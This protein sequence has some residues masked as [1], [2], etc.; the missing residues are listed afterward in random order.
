[1]A[2][3]SMPKN[4]EVMVSQKDFPSFLQHVIRTIEDHLQYTEHNAVTETI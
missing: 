3:F 4:Q 2:V 1:M